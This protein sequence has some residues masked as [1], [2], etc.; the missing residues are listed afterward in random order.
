M[1]AGI[2]PRPQ[3]A[4]VHVII[5]LQLLRL[6]EVST[7]MG[8]GLSFSIPPRQEWGVWP[9]GAESESYPKTETFACLGDEIFAYVGH[10]MCAQLRH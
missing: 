8:R 5:H 2:A 3:G 9:D 7:L 1:L 6:I 4:A 10:E